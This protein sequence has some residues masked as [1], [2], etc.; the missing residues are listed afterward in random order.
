M[1]LAVGGR[2]SGLAPRQW[3]PGCTAR[4][5]TSAWRRGGAL[6]RRGRGLCQG[7]PGASCPQDART[8]APPCAYSCPH[9]PLPPAHPLV[10]LLLGKELASMPTGRGPPKAR[11]G[12]TG[13][14]PRYL[15][16]GCSQFLTREA[17]WGQKGEQGG[18]QVW[19]WPWTQEGRLGT[20]K[21]EAQLQ[22]HPPQVGSAPCDQGPLPVS[23]G[24]KQVCHDHP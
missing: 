21:R 22:A 16:L 4:R 11:A 2:D 7:W 5:P 15:A 17:A 24:H 10:L 20:C 12:H 3:F 18:Q 13:A 19:G 6:W 1:P 8:Q 9:T 23:R 14:G